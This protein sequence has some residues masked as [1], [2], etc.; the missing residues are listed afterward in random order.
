MI[1]QTLADKTMQKIE[2]FE[3]WVEKVLRTGRSSLKR[4]LFSSFSPT[5]TR[6]QPMID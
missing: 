5:A 6:F 3:I 2:L 4:I 1:D